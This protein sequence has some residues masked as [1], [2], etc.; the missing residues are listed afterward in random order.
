MGFEKIVGY[1]YIY[2]IYYEI[3]MNGMS[4]VVNYWDDSENMGLGPYNKGV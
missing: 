2:I 4:I 3:N 1:I